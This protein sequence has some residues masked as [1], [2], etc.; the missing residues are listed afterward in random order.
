[1]PFTCLALAIP[2]DIVCRLL[3]LRSIG[4]LLDQYDRYECRNEES[5]RHGFAVWERRDGGRNVIG[6]AAASRL[7]CPPARP[8][9]TFRHWEGPSGRPG[10]E[11]CQAGLLICAEDRAVLRHIEVARKDAH[12]SLV[13]PVTVKRLRPRTSIR[14]GWTRTRVAVVSKRVFGSLYLNTYSEPPYPLPPG[15]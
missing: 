15:R 10:P 2:I 8:V 7:V 3:P 1:M 11:T 9:Q 4:L 12:S 6:T 13:S 5:G 14:P